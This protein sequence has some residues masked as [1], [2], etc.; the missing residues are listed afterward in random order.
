VASLN[1]SRNW[2]VSLPPHVIL[3]WRFNIVLT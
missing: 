3:L 1:S 2:E